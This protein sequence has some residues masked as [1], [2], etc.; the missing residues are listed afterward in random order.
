MKIIERKTNIVMGIVT[1]RIAL[2]FCVIV[3][4]YLVSLAVR[5]SSNDM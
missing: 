1:R 3:L 4:I 2:I 5:M